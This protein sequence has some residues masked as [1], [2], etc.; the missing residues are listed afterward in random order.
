MLGSCKIDI[1]C[2]GI[3]EEASRRLVAAG[4]QK[5][6]ERA[7]WNCSPALQPGGRY[8]F[9]RNMSTLV[10]FAIGAQYQPGN[11]FHMLGAHTDRCA[12]L[13]WL[14]QNSPTFMPS[15]HR[16]YDIRV[17]SGHLL[18]HCRLREEGGVTRFLSTLNGTSENCC[19]SLVA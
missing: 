2:D 15:A 18:L 14:L 4:F 19:C 3:T 1:G 5:L 6:S 17:V 16:R 11:G 7:E 8:F 13:P 12:F 9:T 10:A